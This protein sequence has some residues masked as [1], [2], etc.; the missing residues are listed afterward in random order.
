MQHTGADK[1]SKSCVGK[2]GTYT[3]CQHNGNNNAINASAHL[4]NVSK[5]SEW[6]KTRCSNNTAETTK[7][8]FSADKQS[9]RQRKQLNWNEMFCVCNQKKSV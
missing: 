3:C 8:K 6:S 9:K 2:S 5:F 4:F 1:Y 7:I